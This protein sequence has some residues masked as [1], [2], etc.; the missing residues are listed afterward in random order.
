M[1]MLLSLFLR[2]T[3]WLYKVVLQFHYEYAKGRKGNSGQAAYTE[4]MY[5]LQKR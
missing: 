3:Q 2:K 4:M 5:E 1:N